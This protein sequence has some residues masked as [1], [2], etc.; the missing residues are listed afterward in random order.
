MTLPVL[1]V[2]DDD[3]RRLGVLDGTLRGRYARDYLVIG[4]APAT[5]AGHLRELRAAGSPVAMVMATSA[6]TAMP[7]T[8]FLAQARV[9]DPAAKRVLVVPPAGPAVPSLQ[10]PV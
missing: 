6:M 2:V 3:P 5:A 1:M 9:I 8:E 10:I 4:E 7:A